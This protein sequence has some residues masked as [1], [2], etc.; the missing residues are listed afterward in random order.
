MLCEGEPPPA[1]PQRS[2][3]AG[4]GRTPSPPRASAGS[5]S[6][7]PHLA[8]GKEAETISYIE[9]MYERLG[10]HEVLINAEIVHVLAD[11]RQ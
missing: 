6:G 4:R 8:Q 9:E 11:R 3:R 2:R 1:K 10:G 5:S 7:E